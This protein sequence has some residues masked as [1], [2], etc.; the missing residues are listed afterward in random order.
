MFVKYNGTGSILA[1]GFNSFGMAFL[2]ENFFHAWQYY[3][4]IYWSE[5]SA[6]AKRFNLNKKE[7]VFGCYFNFDCIKCF[8]DVFCWFFSKNTINDIFFINNIFMSFLV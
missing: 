3:A 8:F 5:K 7:S 2:I 1:W 4:M 6:V